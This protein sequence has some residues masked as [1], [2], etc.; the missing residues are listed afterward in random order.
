MP[1]TPE[2]NVS[3]IFLPEVCS[4]QSTHYGPAEVNASNNVKHLE[5]SGSKNGDVIN[6]PFS[7]SQS[8]LEES[9]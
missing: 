4:S 7:P 8:Q 6:L 1:I 5:E 9:D 3:F 2:K